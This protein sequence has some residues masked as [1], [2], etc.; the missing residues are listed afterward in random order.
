MD[1]RVILSWFDSSPCSQEPKKKDN[2]KTIEDQIKSLTDA[3]VIIGECEQYLH[4][5]Q[6]ELERLRASEA[7]HKKFTE[8]VRKIVSE[9]SIRQEMRLDLIEDAF[10]S[11]DD[12]VRILEL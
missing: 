12:A 5:V 4:G 10:T 9:K 8:K 3:R 11:L 7:Q 1:L 2:M 6:F